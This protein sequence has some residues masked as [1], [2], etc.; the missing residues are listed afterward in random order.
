V[1]IQ[2]QWRKIPDVNK[3]S[4]FAAGVLTPALTK[5]NVRPPLETPFN[6][7]TPK[8]GGQFQMLIETTTSR[9]QKIA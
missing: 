9:Q 5:G 4:R 3:R 2:Q 1:E 7:Y 8:S 6:G